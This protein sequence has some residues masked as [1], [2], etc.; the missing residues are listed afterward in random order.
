MKKSAKGVATSSNVAKSESKNAA[1]TGRK[2]SNNQTTKGAK[3][4][5]NNDDQQK[6]AA[7]MEKIGK[8]SIKSLLVSAFAV[9]EWSGAA[10]LRAA[11]LPLVESG[12]MKVEQYEKAVAAA[13]RAAGVPVPVCSLARLLAV[14][15][16]HRSQ[17]REI[18]INFDNMLSYYRAAGAGSGVVSF[19]WKLSKTLVCATSEI[20]E[21]VYISSVAGTT[22]Q[23]VTGL[24]SF[25]VFEQFNAEKKTA[26][27]EDVEYIRTCLAGVFRAAGRL[28]WS[29]DDVMIEYK[30]I[31]P[32]T[33]ASDD[34]AI[35]RIHKNLDSL[36]KQ[37][38]AVDAE[39]LTLL[40]SLG[41]DGVVTATALPAVLP[42]G[43]RVARIRKLFNSDRQRLADGVR[44]LQFMLS[45]C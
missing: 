42:A 3:G 2:V 20:N 5:N 12:Q 7:I 41:A 29:D 24:L 38:A 11:L 18:G 6:N 28:G 39:L 37:L 23:L 34:K 36:A 31:K 14:A 22:S 27:N 8:S 40:P 10:A 19:R 9:P 33:A 17:L 1:S 16:R 15:R 32:V 45:R 26:R 35:K 4:R 30:S 13:A 44:T 21:F 43:C 25:A